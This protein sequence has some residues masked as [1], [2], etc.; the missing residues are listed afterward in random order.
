MARMML[1]TELRFA[2]RNE[3]MSWMNLLRRKAL[4]LRPMLDSKVLRRWW[5]WWG[6]W[7]G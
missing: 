3:L 4:R 7:R 1:C 5:W 2:E 6:W